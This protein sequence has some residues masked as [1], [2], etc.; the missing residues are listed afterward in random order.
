MLFN[1]NV[2]SSL[3]MAV[4]PSIHSKPSEQGHVQSF[5]NYSA[6]ALIGDLVMTQESQL[7]GHRGR[8][9]RISLPS[10]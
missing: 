5:S 6:E 7:S 2:E 3:T 4:T 1:N 8:R 9:N 10:L